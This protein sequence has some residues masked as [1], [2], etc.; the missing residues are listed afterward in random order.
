MKG[1]ERGTE[2]ETGEWANATNSFQ[3]TEILGQ[4][5]AVVCLSDF[6]CASVRMSN[7]GQMQDQ[8]GFPHLDFKFHTTFMCEK[9]QQLMSAFTWEKK[10][11]IMEKTGLL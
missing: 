4:G 8:R 5:R 7:V 2:P 11:Q 1:V 10:T 3:D 9:L 6:I